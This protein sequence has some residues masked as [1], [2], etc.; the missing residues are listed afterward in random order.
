M[1][2]LTFYA[3]CIVHVTIFSTG[4]KFRPVSIFTQ[5]HALTLVARSYALLLLAIIQTQKAVIIKSIC[6]CLVLIDLFWG[7]WTMGLVI[8]GL[9]AISC[10]NTDGEYPLFCFHPDLVLQEKSSSFCECCILK[11]VN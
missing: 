7:A 6:P 10:L 1:A 11:S 9:Y 3:V 8:R 4:G 5:L 2:T